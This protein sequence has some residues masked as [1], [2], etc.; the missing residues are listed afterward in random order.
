M[1]KRT[2]AC[3]ICSNQYTEDEVSAG[4]PEWGAVHGIRFKNNKTGVEE[5]NPSLCPEHLTMVAMYLDSLV[6]GGSNGMD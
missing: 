3:S 1:I 4:F 6:D 5:D 2:I